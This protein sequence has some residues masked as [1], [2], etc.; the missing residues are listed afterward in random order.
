[1]SM[2]RIDDKKGDIL[3]FICELKEVMPESYGEYSVSVEK[4]LA[5]ERAFE[6]IIEAVNDLAILFIKEK[7][8]LLPSEDE[9]AFDILAK[10][11]MISEELA[12]KLRQAKGMRNILAHQYD[13]IDDEV[14][15][16]AIHDEIIKDVL[17]FL[18][19]ME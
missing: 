11:K 17:K 19:E 5:C 14:I 6:K 2:G 3:L 9:K 12:L 18:E 8:L 7:R 15:F 13:K 1:M 4:R 10:S 16:E